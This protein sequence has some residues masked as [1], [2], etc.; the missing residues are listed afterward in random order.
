MADT[1]TVHYRWVMPEVGS[2]ATTWGGSLNGDLADIDTQVFAAQQA[3]L[4][5]GAISMFAGV[6]PPPN[7]LICDGRSLSTTTYAGLFAVI[8]YTYGGSGGS[9]NLP[10][11]QDKF[12]IGAGPS[13]TVAATGGEATH[14]LT[15]AE[16]AAHSHTIA[17]VSHTHTVSA[18]AASGSQHGTFASTGPLLSSTSITTGP[19]SAGP[20]GTNS[21]GSGTP[22][23]N[24]PPYLV[25][26]FIIR[27]S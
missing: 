15:T 6:G 25:I 11:M 10:N 14:T 4:P 24:L 18:Y 3:G 7:W 20:T 17:P 16:L 23:N 5:I 27:A 19:N 8:L 22:H 12:A 13:H 9:F 21:T 26:N 2:A 1:Q